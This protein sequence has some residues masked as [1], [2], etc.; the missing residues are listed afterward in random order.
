[1]RKVT[2]WCAAGVLAG[3]L[4]GAAGMLLALAAAAGPAEDASDG[5]R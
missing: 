3:V 5:Y 1:M 4:V 2:L